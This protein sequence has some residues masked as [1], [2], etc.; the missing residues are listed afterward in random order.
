MC[1]TTAYAYLNRVLT[2]C[3]TISAVALFHQSHK[4][5]YD[6]TDVKVTYT[7]LWG[8]AGLEVHALFSNKYDFFA[9]IHRVAQYNLIGFFARDKNP[10]KLLKLAQRFGCKDYVD[11]H[12]YVEHCPSSF[13]ITELVIQQVKDGWK[14]YIQ[15]TSTYW[16]FNDRRGQVTIQQ[17]GCDV[18][19]CST[20]E[21]P[22]DESV[23]VWHI[24]TD[25]CYYQGASQASHLKAA[26]SC[27]E[28]S[29]Y[30]VYLLVTSP[31]MLMAGTRASILS[32]AS[33]ELRSMF[34]SDKTL[35]SEGDLTREIH[36]RAQP[37][38]DA[39]ATEA[40]VPRAS[41]LASQLL[42]LDGD[43]RWKV[44]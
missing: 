25:V 14:N 8:T 5:G 11:Q 13:A 17:E 41:K 43:K 32:D 40:F 9:W 21:A 27:R 3:L 2:V 34:K 30:L 23:L 36:R 42:A 37:S 39:A 15:G 38:R 26:A 31:D 1:L 16:A 33:E 7:L 29:N 28:I 6:D 22:F 4:Q 20:L 24:A 19:L 18:E 10:T 44:R 35:P 12:W